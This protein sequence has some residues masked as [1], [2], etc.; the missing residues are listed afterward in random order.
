MELAS[1]SAV[2]SAGSDSE[3]S[4]GDEG[5]QERGHREPDQHQRDERF[6]QRESASCVAIRHG[7][8]LWCK[9]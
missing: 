4:A 9:P 2:A 5:H 1:A 7:Q 8:D 6:E 3:L